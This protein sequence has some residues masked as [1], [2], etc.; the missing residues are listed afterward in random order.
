MRSLSLVLLAALLQILL[1]PG[2]DLSFLA[3]V[4]L[5]PFLAAI[6]DRRP[7]AAFL[8]GCLFGLLSALGVTY[9]LFGSVVDYFGL[10]PVAGAA[11]VLAA[12]LIYAA[13]YFGLFAVL[14]SR[15]R[16]LV[17]S[18]AGVFLV[19]CFWVTAEI[20][21]GH[22]LSED[23]WGILG[24][25]QYRTLPLIQVADWTGVYGV[26]FLLVLINAVLFRVLLALRSRGRG[27]TGVRWTRWDRAVTVGLPGLLLGL[28]LAYGYG[29]LKR[30][31]ESCPGE[32]K[33]VRTALIQANIPS[34]YRWKSIYYGR[35]LDTYLR[36]SLAP[37]AR[38]ADLLVWP[39][40]AVSFHPDRE[41]VF[42]RLITASLEDPPASLLTGGPLLEKNPGGG[43]GRNYNAA[44][45]IT[46]AGIRERYRKIHLMPVSE[47]KPEWLRA[48]LRSPGE[49]PAHFTAGTEATVFPFA[50]GGFSSP[51]CFEMIYPEL[52]RE[53][54][55]NGAGFLV[56]ISNDSWFGPTAG[57]RQHLVFSV[58][59]A[60]EN[61]RDVARAAVTG[62]SAF[63][64]PTGRI[65]YC[66][67]LGSREIG[68][69]DLCPRTALTFYTRHG[70]WFAIGCSVV[71]LC[72]LL[73]S[74][75]RMTVMRPRRREAR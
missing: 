58:F 17:E 69:G 5:V 53:F 70:D 62:L 44:Y 45:L 52:V 68:V 1:F 74:R 49:S 63:I 3:W 4:M 75:P 22:W 33:A 2:F 15:C 27:A 25:S 16:V 28:A 24:Y 48:L 46:G 11:L 71:T 30:F 29:R 73:L 13:V 18:R 20:L 21:R 9:W 65:L 60:V 40:N 39:E 67:G 38:G 59:R 23:P 36:M 34:Q 66:S 51:I 43:G 35:N 8:L 31:E 42:L 61:R 14:V 32:G 6:S 10:S 56:N 50:Q 26:S 72:S 47:R 54:V 41:P 12:S 19:P 57:P 55:R 7:A 37:E 64:A